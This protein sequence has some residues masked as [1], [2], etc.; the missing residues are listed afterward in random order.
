METLHE[1]PALR[2]RLGEWRDDG[3][4]VGLVPTM[5]NLHDGH[6]ALVEA[7]R[8]R[9]DRVVATVFVNPLQFGP[10]ED[11]DSYPRTLNDDARRLA[12]RGCHLLFAPSEAAMYPHGRDAH[13]VVEVP[14]LSAQ[15]C[16]ASRPGHFRGVTTVVAKLFN[17]VQPDLA[18]FG[19]KD[20]QQL[21]L[22]RRMAA[23]LCMDIEILGLPTVR[24]PDGLAMSSRNGY[25][26]AAER[27]R[28]P[29][30]FRT[31]QELA[32]AVA[33]GTPPAQAERDAAQA[34]S[35]AGF[36][37]DY[38]SVRR[39]ADL[40]PAGPQDTALVLLAAAHLGRAR[41]IDNLELDRILVETD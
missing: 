4:R 38:V 32:A 12:H 37:P 27:A 9:A 19:Q 16:G 30:L 39:R 8:A 22:I 31:L 17:L 35:V 20:Y 24:E 5:G 34:L 29:A 33:A 3:L 18:V 10:H 7:A 21:M 26:T 28:A 6:L 15:L 2:A 40:A 1:I 13:T 25:L 36:E 14:G 41:L 11:L 23:D